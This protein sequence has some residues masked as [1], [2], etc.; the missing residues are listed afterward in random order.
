MNSIKKYIFTVLLF[1]SCSAYASGG[2]DNGTPAGAGNLDVDVT[3]N[4]G[5]LYNGGP[6]KLYNKGQ[7]YLVWGWGLT[8]HTDFHGYVSH[9]AGGTNQI[10]YG[11]MHNFFSNDRLDLSTAFGARHRLKQVDVLFPQLLYTFKLP[12]NFEIAGSF[13]NVYNTK[14]RN[15]RG[16]TFDIA[17]RIPIP[18][19]IT[20]S[21]IKDIKVSVGLFKNASGRWIAPS[22]YP[23]YSVDM[24]F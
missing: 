21:S 22:F 4:P 7:S 12:E 23:T 24:K 19:A 20:P 10:Y 18:Q 17:V 9:E 11:L 16:L 15:S 8:N 5:D 6:R 1:F 2:Y 13:T 3:I 14:A